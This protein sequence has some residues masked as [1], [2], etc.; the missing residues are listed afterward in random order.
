MTAHYF[1][2]LP[3]PTL[4]GSSGSGKAD[5]QERLNSPALRG[6]MRK[7][8][9]NDGMDSPVVLA[10]NKRHRCSWGWVSDNNERS[11]K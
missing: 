10:L 2:L 1:G 4:S 9:W 3:D 6:F 11:P 8:R 5:F 7:V